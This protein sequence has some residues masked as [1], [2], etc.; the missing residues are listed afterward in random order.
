MLFQCHACQQALRGISKNF[1]LCGDCWN[2]LV[3]APHP[4]LGEKD[5]PIHTYYSRYW[6]V[7]PS[8]PVLR[9]WKTHG[10]LLYS[11]QILKSDESQDWL[12]H[13]KFH[14]DYLVPIPHR[15]QRAWRWGDS[16][17]E[18]IARWLE[19]VTG[20]PIVR[21]LQ[22]H[23]KRGLH[24]N[25]LNARERLQH[26]IRYDL[27]KEAQTLQE[28]RILLVDDF[29][30]TGHTLKSAARLL[31]EHVNP[32]R[33]DAF[34]LGYRP[35]LFSKT[36]AGKSSST[37]ASRHSSLQWPS[38]CHSSKNSGDLGLVPSNESS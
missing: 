1:P 21:A 13:L 36:T 37:S 23:R 6:L 2:S 26:E 27:S 16:P 25:R 22:A 8:Y 7:G 29:R 34:T 10:G 28:K 3:S 15:T 38:S 4:E 24:Q 17:P 14:V 35:R 32:Q 18:R 19:R 9:R 20:V 5:S 12:P 30:T 31:L 11:R 33:I